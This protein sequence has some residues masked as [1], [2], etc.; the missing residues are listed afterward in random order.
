MI[1]CPYCLNQTV[2]NVTFKNG[3]ISYVLAFFVLLAVGL[4]ASLMLIPIV[5]ILT[6][7]L[8]H[9]YER[10]VFTP[11][12]CAV[13]NEEVGSDGR[14]FYTVGVQD[15]IVSFKV[16]E[17]GCILT[18]KVLLGVAL[19]LCTMALLAYR[20]H[21]LPEQVFQGY[22]HHN[23]PCRSGRTT[24]HLTLDIPITDTWKDFL[25]QC[26]RERYLFEDVTR[27]N[28]AIRYHDRT[29]QGWEGYVIRVED[30]R[31]SLLKYLHHAVTLLVRM[32]P[33]ESDL[34]PDLILTLDSEYAE[35]LG[36]GSTNG[37]PLGPVIEELSRGSKFGFDAIIKS[38]GDLQSTKHFHMRNI[39][40]L[41]GH[42]EI[43]PHL[44]DHGRYE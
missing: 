23:E 2:S 37:T 39:W 9:R 5:M 26:P 30:Y 34:Y 6:K 19:L 36:M 14:I 28:C 43:P 1:K 31:Q 12:R 4:I 38:L 3:F 18:R 33:P 20:V 21:N 42:K 44:H 29:V 10:G 32:D 41:E 17:M 8:V 27:L 11:N 7:Q 22:H 24:T 40:K 15:K 25:M 35:K 16:G 13:C